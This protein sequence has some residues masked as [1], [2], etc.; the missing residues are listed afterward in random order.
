MCTLCWNSIYEKW[1]LVWFASVNKLTFQHGVKGWNSLH[2]IS[3][4]F[5]KFRPFHITFRRFCQTFHPYGHDNS[6][7]AE[8]LFVGFDVV[9]FY[10]FWLKF[11][12][13]D[14]HLRE[15]HKRHIAY[16]SVGV[17]GPTIFLFYKQTEVLQKATRH[18][19][20]EY[21]KSWKCLDITDYI[22]SFHPSYADLY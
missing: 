1:L 11:H 15:Q 20:F 5:I 9:Q 6:T 8:R 19:M 22:Y 13:L 4:F 7:A 16:A 10:E 18:P 17:H 14:R 3:G 21:R 2:L 12:R